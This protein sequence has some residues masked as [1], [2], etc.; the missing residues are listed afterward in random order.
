MQ[1]SGK[2]ELERLRDLY[3]DWARGDYTRADIFD[4]AVEMEGFGMG[5]P[6][7]ASGMDDVGATI[8]EWL[9]AWERPLLIEAEEL[10]PSGDR[11]LVLIRWTGHGKGSGVEM[12]ARGA[13][14]WQFRNGLAVRF[15]VYRDRDEAQAALERG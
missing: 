9:R 15:D 14:L 4:P 6:L 7:R 10:I 1:G 12:E 3:E 8:S 2:T 5:E 13:H 11:I